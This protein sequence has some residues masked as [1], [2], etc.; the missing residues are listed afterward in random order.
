MQ[1]SL[2]LNNLFENIYIKD[3]YLLLQNIFDKTTISILINFYSFKA[4]VLG[5]YQA[6]LIKLLS[7]NIVFN[8]TVKKSRIFVKPL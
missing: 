7:G 4:K 5:K 3:V 1:N 8:H 6:G 2:I